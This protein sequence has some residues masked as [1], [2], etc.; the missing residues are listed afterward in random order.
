MSSKLSFGVLIFCLSFVGAAAPSLSARIF[1]EC[2]TLAKKVKLIILAE[3]ILA[4]E[5]ENLSLVKV[6]KTSLPYF[7]HIYLVLAYSWAIIKH[8][9]KY[10]LVFLRTVNIPFFI[11]GIIARNLLKK[12]LVVLL[13]SSQGSQIGIKEKIY[14]K[15]AKKTLIISDAIVASSEQTMKDTEIYL[16]IGIDRAKLTIINQ[17][18]DALRFKPEKNHDDENILLCVARIS[19]IKRIEYIIE[20]IPHVIKSVPNIKLKIVGCVQEKNYLDDL[21]EL[22]S[23]LKCEKYVEFVGPV[24]HDKLVYHYN[25][26]RIFI[27]SSKGEG[28]SNATLEAMAC[29]KPV[30]ITSSGGISDYVEDGVNG[31]VVKD[32]QP[33]LLSQ[34][35]VTL[36]EDKQYREKIGRAARKTVEERYSGHLLVN[37][38]IDIFDQ[39]INSRF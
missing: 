31:L 20:A 4:E 2:V 10:D 33:K 15:L 32:N 36:L 38:L 34:K 21:K 28:I 9:K 5:T 1:E 17:G 23:K 27:L 25:S 8:R 29:E 18:I 39:V 6:S 22:V 13:S 16:G 3:D 26:A 35:I 19:P 7:N 11:F 30:I 37:N 14:R 24:P 12:K